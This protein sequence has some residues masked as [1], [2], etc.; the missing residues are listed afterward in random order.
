EPATVRAVI[1]GL[2]RGLQRSGGSLRRLL[3]GPGST[4]FAPIFDRAAQVAGA[5]GP[6]PSRVEAIRLL[7]LGNADRALE[8]VTALLDA[9]QPAEVQLAA[10]QTI[11]PLPDPRVADRVIEH[12]KALSPG[13]R[14]EAV[15]VLFARAP[16]LHKLL[17]AIE[18]GQVPPAEIDPL[19]RAQLLNLKD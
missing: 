8:V 19:R 12:W 13:V 7:G 18:A 4:R 1:L 14:R 6:V 17:D 11:A 16:R 9:R 15:E 3:E 10:L 5:E 2:G